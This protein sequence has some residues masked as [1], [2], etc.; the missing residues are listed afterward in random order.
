MEITKPNDIFV[1]TLNNPNATTYDF[2]SAQLNPT[3]TSLFLKE[4]YK[5]SDFVKNKF[6]TEDGKFDDVAFDN[7]YAKAKN[8][9]EEMTNEDYIK[10]LDQIQYS[11]LDVTRPKDAKVFKV[12]VEFSKDINPLRELYSRTAINSIDSNTLSLR[13]IAQQGKIFNPKTKT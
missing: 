3:N 11:P 9:Y 13:E 7:F 4:E 1:A 8:H 2:M 5:D 10:S 12:D 6:K